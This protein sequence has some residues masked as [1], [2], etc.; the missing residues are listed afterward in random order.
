MRV[1]VYKER[2]MTST[3][4]FSLFFLFFLF[5]AFLCLFSDL[6]GESE[7]VENVHIVFVWFCRLLLHDMSS[8]HV[9]VHVVHLKIYNYK[10]GKKV[11]ISSEKPG[12]AL[13]GLCLLQM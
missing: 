13:L 4:L 2:L 12:R 1:I 9:Y 3:S 5:L 11:F 6:S 7:G 10:K 8:C